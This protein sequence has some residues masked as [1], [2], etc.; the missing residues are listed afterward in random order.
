MFG[1]LY[2]ENGRKRPLHFSKVEC[3]QLVPSFSPRS[4]L[5][6]QGLGYTAQVGIGRRLPT[7]LGHVEFDCLR[8]QV[9]LRQPPRQTT[10]GDAH[11]VGARSLIERVDPEAEAMFKKRAEVAIPGDTPAGLDQ[12]FRRSG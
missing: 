2:V 4:R 1:L 5:E 11:T 6:E 7:R 9:G 8:R 10:G 3:C 12:G